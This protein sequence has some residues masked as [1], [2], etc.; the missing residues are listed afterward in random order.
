MVDVASERIAEEMIE[1]VVH[2]MCDDQVVFEL[3]QE[4][5]FST[6]ADSFFWE[7]EAQTHIRN[8]ILAKVV[9]EMVTSEI[10]RP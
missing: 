6:I 2:D 7:N 5:Q 10:A 1:D 9:R 8:I 3:I 4:N